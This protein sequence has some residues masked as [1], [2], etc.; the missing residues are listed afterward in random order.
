M[1][2]LV[3]FFGTGIVGGSSI[4]LNIEG[5][6][7]IGLEFGKKMVVIIGAQFIKFA[8]RLQKSGT[9]LHHQIITFNVCIYVFI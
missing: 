5:L 3:V 7:G 8:T 4:C 2:L 1:F 6:F 9:P